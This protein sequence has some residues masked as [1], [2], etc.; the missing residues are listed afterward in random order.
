VIVGKDAAAAD[1][2]KAAVRPLAFGTAVLRLDV[3][4]VV[5]QNLPPSLAQTIPNLPA[6]RDAQS[7]DSNSRSFALICSG[8]TCQPPIFEAEELSRSLGSQAQPAA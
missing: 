6:L 3:D 2:Y 1:L 7:S 5:A 4:K 8:F